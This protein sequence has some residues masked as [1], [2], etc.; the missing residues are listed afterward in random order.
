MPPARGW[1]V[2]A[3]PWRPKDMT[4][5]WN[6]PCG[7]AKVIFLWSWGRSSTCQ[8]PLVRSRNDR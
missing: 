6:N 1:K 2:V 5:K 4:V 8:Y 7:V 3:A